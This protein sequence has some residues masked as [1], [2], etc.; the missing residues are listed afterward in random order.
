MN[1]YCIKNDSSY[2]MLDN[3][4]KLVSCNKKNRT[5]FQEKKAK[6]IINN[7]P[8]TLKNLNYSLEKIVDEIQN[9]E[10]IS[11]NEALIKWADKF[12][13]CEDILQEAQERYNLLSKQLSDS[14]NELI[15]FLHIIEI[16]PNKDLYSGWQ[17]YKRIQENRK[18]RRR[19]KDEMMI[20]H[21]I[22]QDTSTKTFSR[23]NIEKAIN[24]LF[25]RKYSFRI[26]DDDD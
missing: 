7:L 9:I 15:D 3:F 6:N 16:E 13:V 14:D 1:Y 12:G 26:V 2:L 22:L 10:N 24:G 20:L 21:N 17:M 23:K 19:L 4:G 25:S 5:I 18:H 11:N 8:K